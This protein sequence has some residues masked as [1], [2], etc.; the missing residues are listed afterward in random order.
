MVAHFVQSCY[1]CGSCTVQLNLHSARSI[2]QSVS[3]DIRILKCT[4]HWSLQDWQVSYLFQTNNFLLR[5]KWIYKTEPSYKL[6]RGGADKSLA[7]ST[8]RCRRTE[9]IVS[10]E[11]VVCSCAEL[12]VF[13]CYRGWTE[14]CHATRAIS[15]TRRRELTSSSFL[16]PRSGAEGNSRH[17]DRNIGGTCTIVCHRQKL[18]GPV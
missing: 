7:R 15:T 10:L 3:A 16:A 6:I 14:A 4:A 8:S 17:S 1:A 11:R 13:S 5:N 18:G 12:Q 2:V 9:L